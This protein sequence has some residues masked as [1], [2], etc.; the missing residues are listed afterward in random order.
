MRS[1]VIKLQI[2]VN[3]ENMLRLLTR[4]MVE[5]ARQNI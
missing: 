5:T 1:L 3:R 2:N 4:N